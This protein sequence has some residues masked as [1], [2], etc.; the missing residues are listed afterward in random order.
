M[1]GS[2]GSSYNCYYQLRP[3]PHARLPQN[4]L[5]SPHAPILAE[6]GVVL[7][8]N[9][10]HCLDLEQVLHVPQRHER[11]PLRSAEH[12]RKRLLSGQR[13]VRFGS[14]GLGWVRLWLEG[15]LSLAQEIALVC[16]RRL[17]N[18]KGRYIVLVV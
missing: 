3:P 10:Y 4:T 12:R 1:Y 14:F 8:Q 11:R 2:V 16:G 18:C 6:D 13:S 9:S 7:D 15:Q 17:Q 5:F